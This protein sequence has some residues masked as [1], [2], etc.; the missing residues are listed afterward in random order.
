MPAQAYPCVIGGEKV[1]SSD[2]KTF[3]DINPADVE[4]VVGEFPLLSKEDVV[5]AIEAAREAQMKWA[6][7][8]PPERGRILIRAAQIMAGQ[9]WPGP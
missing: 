4:D 9:R 6:L 7:I 5:R 8:P 1:F 3:K 2:G